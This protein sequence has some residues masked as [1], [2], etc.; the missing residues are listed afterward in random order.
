MA[1]AQVLTPSLVEKE[2]SPLVQAKLPK[3]SSKKRTLASISGGSCVLS[4]LSIG[5]ETRPQTKST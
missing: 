3:M 2:N 4:I 5:A 1:V